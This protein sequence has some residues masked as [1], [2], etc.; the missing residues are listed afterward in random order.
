MQQKEFKILMLIHVATH[1]YE[2]LN[3]YTRLYRIYIIRRQN[4]TE[5]AWDID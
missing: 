3:V 4:F 5:F 2:L 1:V